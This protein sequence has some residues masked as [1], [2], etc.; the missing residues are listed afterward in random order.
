MKYAEKSME[1]QIE[2]IESLQRA[3]VI[4]APVPS[5][6]RK[7]C[8]TFDHHS[9]KQKKEAESRA[10]TQAGNHVQLKKRQ[11]GV[12][13]ISLVFALLHHVVLEHGCGLGI[14]SVQAIQNRVDMLGPIWRIVKRYSHLCV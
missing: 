8:G 12:A 9:T 1:S 3:G 7:R 14:V 4:Q 6:N 5:G 13:V 11:V 2:L 10:E